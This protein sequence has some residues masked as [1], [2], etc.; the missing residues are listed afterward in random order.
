LLR[1]VRRCA[2]H[3]AVLTVGM[4]LTATG[5]VPV[6]RATLAATLTRAIDRAAPVAFVIVGHAAH[7]TRAWGDVAPPGEDCLCHCGSF[8]FGSGCSSGASGAGTAA[9]RNQVSHGGALIAAVGLRDERA[10]LI[11]PSGPAAR[12]VVERGEDQ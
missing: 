8:P 10:L 9:P 6:E 1:A 4:V 3:R 5:L 2:A 11:E 12:R 7:R